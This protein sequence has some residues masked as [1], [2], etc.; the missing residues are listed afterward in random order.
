MDNKMELP[1]VSLIV[2]TKNRPTFL[3]EALQSICGQSYPKIEIIVVNDGGECNVSEIVEGFISHVSAIQLIQLPISAGRSGAANAGLKHVTGEWAGFLDDDD[4]LETTHIEQLVKIA[5]QNGVKVIYSGTKVIQVN[6][7]GTTNEITEYNVPY[8]AERLLFQNFIPIHSVLFHRELIDSG[9]CF[10]TSFDFFEDWDF[11]IQLSQKTDFLHSTLVTA[12]Y[13]IHNDASGVH[14]HDN[15]DAFLQMYSK[16]LSGFH[17]E[18][19]FTLLQKSHQWTDEKISALQ[20][21]NA[22]WLQE[23]DAQLL[24]LGDL[25][26]HTLEVIAEKDC[27]LNSIKTSVFWRLFRWLLK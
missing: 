25:Y 1:L 13:R 7:D 22:K 24:E 26:K 12:I 18:K 21:R 16:W 19:V 11:W 15:K 17:V 4:L 10:D 14:Q 27:E 9:A 8:S 3:Q 20:D 23:R 6:Q 5:L 2:R